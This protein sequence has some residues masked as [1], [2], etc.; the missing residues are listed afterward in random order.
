MKLSLKLR[1]E[2]PPRPETYAQA[3]ALDDEVDGGEPR[4]GAG[5]TVGDAGK[6]T[7]GRDLA[8]GRWTSL[9]A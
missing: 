1:R 5:K 7:V 9:K 8:T 6:P 4:V 3:E 2:R